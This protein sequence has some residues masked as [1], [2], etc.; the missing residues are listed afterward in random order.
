VL[1]GPALVEEIDQMVGAAATKLETI[2][3]KVQSNG[4]GRGRR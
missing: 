2:R 3:P 4:N 1:A